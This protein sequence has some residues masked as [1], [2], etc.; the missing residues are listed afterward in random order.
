[1]GHENLFMISMQTMHVNL[2]W[3][4]PSTW[5]CIHGLF[6]PSSA[7]ARSIVQNIFPMVWSSL[8]YNIVEAASLF[9][10]FLLGT[11]PKLIMGTGRPPPHASLP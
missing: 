11:R 3:L 5:L 1:M 2:S 4:G 10:P 8:S 6:S 7:M 9:E